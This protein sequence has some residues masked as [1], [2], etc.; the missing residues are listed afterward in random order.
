MDLPYESEFQT[1][2]AKKIIAKRNQVNIFTLMSRV[3]SSQV[4]FGTVRKNALNSFCWSDSI[5]S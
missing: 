4:G 3:L 1:V 2:G 5:R